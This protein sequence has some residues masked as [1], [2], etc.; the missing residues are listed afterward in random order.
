MEREEKISKLCEKVMVTR[1]EAEAA[2]NACNDDILDAVLYLEMLGKVRN[3]KAAS[4]VDESLAELNRQ[5]PPKAS[6]KSETFF[7]ALGR[8]CAWL[9]GLIKIACDNC[10][11][12]DRQG[13]TLIRIP[14]IIPIVLLIPCFWL[15]LILLIVGLFLGFHYSFSGP[16]FAKD[17]KINK[18]SQRAAEKAEKMKNDFNRGFDGGDKTE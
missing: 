8:F 7:E 10:L 4:Y 13:E 1:E 5:D 3:P 16:A 6:H 11:Q 9:M 2:L 12:I 14:L 17:S 18:M 15:V